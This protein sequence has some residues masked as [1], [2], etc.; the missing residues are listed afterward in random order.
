MSASDETANSGSDRPTAS[1]FA[2]D[3]AMRRLVKVPEPDWRV[4][5]REQIA[6][7]VRPLQQNQGVGLDDV[8][9]A[10][11]LQ[12]SRAVEPKEIDVIDWRFWCVVD[13]HER[14]SRARDLVTNAITGADRT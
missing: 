3:A 9:P 7:P 11:I 13:V 8:I 12:V 6:R 1:P 10:D 2:I 5:G 14:E 4:I